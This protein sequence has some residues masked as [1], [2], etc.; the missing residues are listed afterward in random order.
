MI[1]QTM[2]DPANDRELVGPV[3]QQRHVLADLDPGHRRAD[4]TELASVFHR[5]IGL[6]V[7]RVLMRR[8]ATQED[9]NRRSS[10]IRFALGC[11]C[12]QKITQRKS[13]T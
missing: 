2:R 7:K 13:R 5:R 6:H 11:V 3:G 10:R 1:G 12:T 9:Q 8:P 4:G